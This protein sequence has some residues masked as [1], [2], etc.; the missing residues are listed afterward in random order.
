MSNRNSALSNSKSSNTYSSYIKGF[1]ANMP[2]NL[3][4]KKD[5]DEYYRDAIKKVH[6]KLKEERNATLSH[7]TRNKEDNEEDNKRKLTPYNKFVK[8]M[9]KE[10]RSKFPND[11]ASEIMINIGAEWIKT[12]KDAGNTI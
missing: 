6:E 8:K 11:S 3:D 7:K 2:D 5:I 4:T 10:L 12:K 9:F 1:M